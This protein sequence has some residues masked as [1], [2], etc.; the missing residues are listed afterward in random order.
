MTNYKA[1]KLFNNAEIIICIFIRDTYFHEIENTNI[2][3]LLEW[4]IKQK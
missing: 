4:H 3:Y 2:N 1:K